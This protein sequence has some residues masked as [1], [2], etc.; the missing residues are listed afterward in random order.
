MNYLKKYN[1]R[2][3]LPQRIGIF[4][5]LIGLVVAE[6]IVN[7][8]ENFGTQENDLNKVA[9][10]EEELAVLITNYELRNYS[11]S[12]YASK[13]VAIKDSIKP[14]NP[15]DLTKQGW[16]KLGFSSKQSEVIMKYKQIL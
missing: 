9:Q 10:L 2:L 5:L 12:N 14:F 11:S 1:W 15:N 16:E 13:F 7:N 4:C 8:T 6:L 3:T